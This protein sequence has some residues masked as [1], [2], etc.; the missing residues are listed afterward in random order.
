VLVVV[1]AVAVMEPTHPLGE[2]V[3]TVV[4]MAAGAAAAL[5]WL[6]EPLAR[7]VRELMV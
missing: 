2:M 7:A 6:A 4:F 1:A 5:M 3:V